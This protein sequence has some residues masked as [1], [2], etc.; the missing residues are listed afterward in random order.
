MSDVQFSQRVRK[1]NK[2][3]K[4]I[5]LFA[6]LGMLGGAVWATG[7]IQMSSIVAAAMGIGVRFF[8]P[9][10]ASMS[11]PADERVGLESHPATGNYHLGA[12]GGGLVVASLVTVGQMAVQGYGLLTLWAGGGALVISFFVLSELLPEE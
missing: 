3:S 4:V 1:A 2:W 7:D 8:I 9:Y 11:V 12:A 5:A 10:Q 6:A